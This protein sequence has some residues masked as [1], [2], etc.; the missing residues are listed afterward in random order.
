MK[1]LILVGYIACVFQTVSAADY[2]NHVRELG[3]LGSG[4]SNNIKKPENYTPRYTANPPMA[5]QY[6]G[7]GLSLP[8]QYGESKIAGCKNNVADSDLYLRQECEGVNFI[9]NNKTQRPDVTISANEKLVQ[10]TQSISGDPAETLDK[11]KWKYPVNA[12][13]SIG[14]IPSTA[15]PTETIQIPAVVTNKTCNEYTG[16]ELFLCEVALK[17][18]VDPNWNYSC[19][20]TKYKNEHYECAKTLKVVCETQPDCTTS[21]IEAASMQGDMQIS[22]VKDSGANTHTL[23][24][25]SIGDNYFRDNQYDR[26]MRVNIKNLKNLS[27]FTLKRVEYDD[28]LVVKVNDKIVYSSYKNQLIYRGN[29][30]IYRSNGNPITRKAVFDAAGNRIGWPERKTS[31]IKDLNIDIRPYL[32][33]GQ[34]VIWTRTIVGGGGE[35][36]S[37]FSVHQYCEPVCMESWVN[38]CIEY[39]RRAAP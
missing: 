28:W 25:G 23:I 11:Y 19:L 5:E 15:C 21:G 6:Y 30:E 12:D 35:S 26:E 3:G 33:E 7:G 4:V 20:E 29:Y 1:R 13:G 27:T 37:I 38:G 39:E 2:S 9:V 24:F 34:N 8:T 17:V 16:A 31:W 36:A 32:R 14:S 18:K 22:F 10:G